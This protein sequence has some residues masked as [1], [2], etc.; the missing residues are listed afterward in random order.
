MPGLVSSVSMPL[1]TSASIWSDGCVITASVKSSVMWPLLTRTSIRGGTSQRPS[2]LAQPL[3][4]S[5][6][7]MSF[8]LRPSAPATSP[9]AA[10]RSRL[11]AAS[12][13]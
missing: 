12:S 4:R 11:S 7:I 13:A 9:G 10:G 1:P 6:R 2:R 5:M 8:G 3:V